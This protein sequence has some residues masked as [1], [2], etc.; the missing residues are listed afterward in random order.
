ML[1]YNEVILLRDKLVNGEISIASAQ[2]EYW[3]DFKEGQKSWETKD[4]KE[5]RAKVIK[6][7]C[8]ICGSKETLTIQHRSHPKKYAEYA[9]EV[10]RAYTE[11]HID[12]NPKVDE[13]AF[14]S[15]IQTHY[16]HSPVP[17]C[18]NCTYNNLYRRR[19]KTPAYRCLNCKHEFDDPLYKSADELITIFLADEDAFIVRDKC[20]VSKDKWQN[21]HSLSNIKY[22]MQRN[23]AKTIDADTIEKEAFLLYLNDAIHYLSFEDAITACRKCAFNYDINK[24]E[25]CPECSQFYKGLHYPTC[26]QCL[27][28]DR[29]N[30]ALESIEFGKMMRDMHRDLGID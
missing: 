4:W 23:Q 7:K 19:R 17:L 29:R 27:P 5:R 11:Q 10:T 9:R 22:W 26:I 21:Y 18:P 15:Y 14:R 24:M 3:K 2:A 20:F 16:D 6:D 13:T 1:T 8:E 25:L 28:E 12:A 30:A